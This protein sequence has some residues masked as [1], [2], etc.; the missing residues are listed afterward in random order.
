MNRDGR[1][2]NPQNKQVTVCTYI[3]KSCIE[4]MEKG[5]THVR[6][7]N[8]FERFFLPIILIKVMNSLKDM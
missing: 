8:Y 5:K 7:D 3:L 1:H 6:K 4:R 2:L